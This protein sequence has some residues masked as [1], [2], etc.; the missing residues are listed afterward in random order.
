MAGAPGQQNGVH[1]NVW[2]TNSTGIASPQ[3]GRPAMTGGLQPLQMLQA[4]RSGVPVDTLQAVN[5]YTER[6]T[7]FL[8][9]TLP[10]Y[11][12]AGQTQRP[13]SLFQ[14]IAEAGNYGVAGGPGG[15]GAPGGVGTDSG[16]D[17]SGGVGDGGGGGGGSK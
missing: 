11:N 12:Y 3:V 10:S 1:G 8:P 9:N 15:D 16:A 17:G 14:A 5:P 7:Q 4:Y 6:P 13:M 2:D